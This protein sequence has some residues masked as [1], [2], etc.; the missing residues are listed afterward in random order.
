M[1]LI[2]ALPRSL[3][4]QR[5]QQGRRQLPG[6]SPQLGGRGGI[7]DLPRSGL[8][9]HH[10][11][12]CI[13]SQPQGHPDFC[14][15]RGAGI[16]QSHK[17][18][19]RMAEPHRE[20]MEGVTVASGSRDAPGKPV[21]APLGLAPAPLPA[22]LQVKQSQ[23]QEH[24]SSQHPFIKNNYKK[25]YRLQYLY[26]TQKPLTNHKPILQCYSAQGCGG[27][28]AAHHHATGRQ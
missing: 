16:A 22:Q 19:E 12:S 14:S 26:T 21:Q 6:L 27:S 11:V 28:G 13:T 25:S 5:E 10:L 7:R 2:G 3:V 20:D 18:C 23:T 8:H 24:A 17:A 1:R 4:K 9:R 15:S